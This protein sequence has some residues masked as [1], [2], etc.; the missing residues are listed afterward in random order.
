[1]L[2]AAA[3]F[4][5]THSLQLLVMAEIHTDYTNEFYLNV[6]LPLGFLGVIEAAVFYIVGCIVAYLPVR[7]VVRNLSPLGAKHPFLYPTIGMLFGVL[8]LPFC[9]AFSFYVTHPLDPDS[10]SYLA[11]CAEFAL[12]MTV[13]GV[14][15]GYL[16]H[17]EKKWSGAHLA[18]S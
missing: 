14:A 5:F 9:A 16:F 3:A 2:I 8:F 12:P 7:I 4:G 1:M 18:D 11:R 15:G 17:V 10:P 6:L 13:A